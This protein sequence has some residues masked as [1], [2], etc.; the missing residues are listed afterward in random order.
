MISNETL[1]GAIDRA[2]RW[3]LESGI[4]NEKPGDANH[5]ATSAWYDEPARS[6]SFLYSEIAGY[7]ITMHCYL[8]S[9]NGDER[10]IEKAMLAADWLERESYN[11]EGFRCRL[12]SGEPD[13]VNWLCSFDNAMILNGFANLYR[14]TGDPKYLKIATRTADWLIAKMQN[15]DGSFKAKLTA[16]TLEEIRTPERWSSQ[17]AVL[18]AKHAIGLAN[19]HKL[20]GD[21]RYRDAAE[22]ICDWSIQHMEGN[23]RFV[24]NPA[25]GDTYMHPHCY[26]IEGLLAA[27]LA[28]G[29]DRYMPDIKE[30]SA[31]ILMGIT[32]KEGI[33]QHF[34]G[35]AF[36]ADEHVDSMS[37]S[38]RIWMLLS[39]E[40]DYKINDLILDSV[41][42][43]L[44]DLQAASDD[45]RADGAFYYG[46][47]DGQLRK[48]ASNHG[49]MFALQTLLMYRDYKAGKLDFDMLLYV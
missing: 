11:G 8:H 10:H 49:T 22:S 9:G 39:G 20:T 44:L 28:L 3:L 5:G 18:H 40:P 30:A 36:S 32:S 25:V 21:G 35:A 4:L 1:D 33:S 2:T 27:A 26:A 13:F 45:P 17:P 12:N 31:W 43:R 14:T 24:T 15:P 47:V 38:A 46:T 42:K 48:H 34:D 16:D 7:S 19:I 41:I 29:L 6:Y 37:Q 23:G